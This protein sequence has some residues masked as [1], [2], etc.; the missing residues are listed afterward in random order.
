MKSYNSKGPKSIAKFVKGIRALHEEFL[1]ITQ[2][3]YQQIYVHGYCNGNT[4]EDFQSTS[5]GIDPVVVRT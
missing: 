2:M 3:I 4:L 5:R 1:I